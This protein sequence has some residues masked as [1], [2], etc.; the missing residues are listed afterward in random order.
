MTLKQ[1]Y[2]IHEKEIVSLI[3]LALKEDKV[4][5]DI[6]TSL[7]FGKGKGR[8]VISAVLLCKQDGVLAG[9]EIF[10]RVYKQ[11]NKKITFLANHKDGD[12]IF[13]GNPI[14]EIKGP[15]KDLLVGERTSLN[16]LQRMSGVATLT[17][18][19]VSR[20]KY[21][22]SIVLH[23]RKTTPNFR[24]FELAAVKTGGGDFHR[25]DL[26][27]SVM[28]KDNHEIGGG[29]LEMALEKIDFTRLNKNLLKKFEVEVKSMHELELIAGKYSKYVKVVMLDNF[30]PH[31]I[32]KAVQILKAKKIKIEIS[33]GINDENFDKM[34]YPGVDYY[35]IGM[36][37]HSYKSLDFSLEF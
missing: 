33:G 34:Q 25:Y 31:E 5:N 30:N 13:K 21:E 3:A 17:R 29:S 37:T 22:G 20:L 10:K 2:K 32:A 6:T 28:I 36:L 1:Y 16:F 8:R 15:V 11:V 19:F 14:L 35:S 12:L 23:T 27:S 24:I 9:I 26:S 18:G 4:R 7:T